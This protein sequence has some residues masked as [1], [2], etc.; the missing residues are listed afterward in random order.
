MWI[1]AQYLLKSAWF[2][3]LYPRH[4]VSTLSRH[5]NIFCIRLYRFRIRL[6]S[7]RVSEWL[8]SHGIRL[9]WWLYWRIQYWLCTYR[10]GIG[11]IDN[12]RTARRIGRALAVAWV[13][14]DWK[15]YSQLTIVW[16]CVITCIQHLSNVYR[17][18]QMI[19][20]EYTIDTRL[21]DSFSSIHYLA[22]DC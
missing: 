14:M 9:V 5:S 1:H 4:P 15:L 12:T 10:M 11:S 20:C 8:Y 13:D 19:Q 16:A 7:H 3:A 2:F 18:A 6:S 21:R 22:S 17:R